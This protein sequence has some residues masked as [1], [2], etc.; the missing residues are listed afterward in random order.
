[1]QHLQVLNGLWQVLLQTAGLCAK[2]P[3]NVNINWAHTGN[4][5]VNKNYHLLSANFVPCAI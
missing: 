2:M 1:M 4:N 3:N 5:Y